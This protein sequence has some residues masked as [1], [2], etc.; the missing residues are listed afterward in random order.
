M[1]KCASCGLASTPGAVRCELCRA[2][3][4][5]RR[6]RPALASRSLP[7]QAGGAPQPPP[8]AVGRFLDELSRELLKT[9]AQFRLPEPPRWLR[10]LAWTMLAGSLLSGMALA[11]ML[12]GLQATP[13]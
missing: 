3:L 4:P 2:P 5:R 1:S 13:P 11:G 10:A 12:L 9:E 8:E 7:P 6:H